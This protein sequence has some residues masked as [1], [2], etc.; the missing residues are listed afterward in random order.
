MGFPAPADH[1]ILSVL[2]TGTSCSWNGDAAMAELVSQL[3]LGR[4]RS[5]IDDTLECGGKIR[6]GDSAGDVLVFCSV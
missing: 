2:S 1:C 6:S 4:A 3:L 5:S